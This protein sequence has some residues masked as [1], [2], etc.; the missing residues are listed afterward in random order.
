MSTVA[1]TTRKIPAAD[2]VV[3]Y[4]PADALE[5]FTDVPGV[6]ADP[7]CGRRDTIYIASVAV[8]PQWR[9]RGLGIL[10]L[11]FLA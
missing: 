2:V 10:L 7:H 5:R 9:R 8:A 6:E 4:L 3:G 11:E 1:L